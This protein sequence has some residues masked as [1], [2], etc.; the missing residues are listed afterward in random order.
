M[1]PT[2]KILANKA[3]KIILIYSSQRRSF[4]GITEWLT[5]CLG[6]LYAKHDFL[7][8]GSVWVGGQQSRFTS[9]FVHF[10]VTQSRTNYLVSL[11]IHFLVSEMSITMTFFMWDEWMQSPGTVTGALLLLG[12]YWRLSSKNDWNNSMTSGS[13]EVQWLRQVHPWMAV[14]QGSGSA[15]IEA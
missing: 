13:P 6:G 11:K 9:Q 8:W 10:L 7:E 15:P 14:T 4:S 3:K 2:Q 5:A 12:L 1:G